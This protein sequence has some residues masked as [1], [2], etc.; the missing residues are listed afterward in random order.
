MNEMH[1]WHLNVSESHLHNN[2][3]RTTK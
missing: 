3:F 1:N 2:K